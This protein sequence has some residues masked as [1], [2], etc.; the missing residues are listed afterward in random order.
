MLEIFCG[1]SGIVIKGFLSSTA[2]IFSAAY[3]PISKFF[4]Q[5]LIW[6]IEKPPENGQ[7]LS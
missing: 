5:G 1:L 6:A 7:K 4:K 2:K 3:L